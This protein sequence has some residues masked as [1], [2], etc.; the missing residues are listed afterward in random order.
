MWY[1]SIST[2]SPPVAHWL[3][4]CWGCSHLWL[5]RLV[6]HMTT[7]SCSLN[8][9]IYSAIVSSLTKLH[10]SLTKLHSY[11]T[12]L[13]SSLTKLHSPL[14]K[15]SFTSH[16]TLIHLSHYLHSTILSIS[17]RVP[18]KLEDYQPCRYLITTDASVSQARDSHTS[19]MFQVTTHGSYNHP[20]CTLW[21]LD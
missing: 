16:Q 3:T 17:V 14:I 15:L 7:H 18:W 19:W 10:S 12:K 2:W 9:A 6:P 13:H 8:H 4:T 5:L 11:L 21:S 20:F 1:I